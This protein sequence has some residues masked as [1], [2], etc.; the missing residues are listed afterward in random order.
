MW[1]RLAGFQC[2]IRSFK[3][4]TRVV[5]DLGHVELA[6]EL[7][8]VTQSVV[9]VCQ[10]ICH[11]CRIKHESRSIV[12]AVPTT[13]LPSNQFQSWLP[14]S[15]EGVIDDVCKNSAVVKHQ[16]VFLL[17][18]V[19]RYVVKSHLI[20]FYTKFKGLS[21]PFRG[22]FAYVDLPATGIQQ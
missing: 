3:H 14:E 7:H 13:G 5:V 12:V 2:P 8:R 21:Y 19:Q 6:L 11:L 4:R 17:D 20:G 10:P 1:H 15:C 9:G 18:S 22:Y 16:Q